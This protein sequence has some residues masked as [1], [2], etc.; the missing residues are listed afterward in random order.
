MNNVSFVSCTRMYLKEMHANAL[1]N[2][3]QDDNKKN[4]IVIEQ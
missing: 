3:R 2:R 1:E 4:Q